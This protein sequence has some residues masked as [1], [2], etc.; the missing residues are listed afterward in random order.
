[1]HTNSD[2]FDEG[3]FYALLR[4]QEAADALRV[5]F[6]LHLVDKLGHDTLDWQSLS[7][8]FGFTDQGARTFGYLLVSMKV[9]EWIDP[10]KP[11]LGLRLTELAKN[12]LGERSEQSRLP[13][14]SMGAS[15]STQQLINMLQGEFEGPSLYDAANDD[16]LMESAATDDVAREIAY[17]LASRAKNFAEPLAALI[18]DSLNKRPIVDEGERVVMADLGAGSPYV[19]L[20]CLRK[21]KERMSAVLVDQATGLKFAREMYDD[22]PP[23]QPP[24][25]F[26]ESNIFEQVPSANHYLLSNTVHDWL[27]QQCVEL[28]KNIS[29]DAP[30]RVTIMIHEPMLWP[31]NP[32]PYNQWDSLWKSCYGLTLYKLTGGQGSC[33]TLGEHISMLKKAGFRQACLPESTSDGCVAVDFQREEVLHQRGA[34]IDKTRPEA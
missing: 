13:Y 14:L 20:S 28:Y 31:G 18:S 25:D 16:C 2:H 6:E 34:E 19:A 23:P 15:D 1:M 4:F 11:E 10:M 7:Q 29:A 26:L 5:C 3:N 24:L 17:G 30:E 33:Y 22:I 12:A 27:P 9:L 8:T 32:T 21:Q